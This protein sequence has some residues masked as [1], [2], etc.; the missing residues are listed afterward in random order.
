MKKIFMYIYSLHIGGGAENIMHQLSLLL[1][2]NDYDVVVCSMVDEEPSF[3]ENLKANDIRI[4]RLKMNKRNYFFKLLELY[5]LLRK[6][7]PA[8]FLAWLWPAIVSG[9]LIAKMAGLK[10]RVANLRGPAMTKSYLKIILDRIFSR[11]YTHYIA[12]TESVKNIFVKR[13][14]FKQK[15]IT[16]INNGIDFKKKSAKYLKKQLKKEFALAQ[17]EFVVGTIGR[18]YPEKNQQLL[19]AAAKILKEQNFKC[20]IFLVGNGPAEKA[21][22]EQIIANNLLEY[23]I[24]PG[25]QSDVYKFLTMYDLFVLPSLYEGHPSS[26]LQAWYLKL[27]I[28]ATKVIGIKDIVID[29]YNG[30][31]FSKDEPAELARIIINMKN[32]PDFAQKIA[33][34]GYNTVKEKY[35]IE[36]MNK[37]YLNYFEQLCR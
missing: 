5:H 35:N 19:V 14:K 18:L 25:W 31:L 8:V 32:Y 17:N 2:K 34:N 15:K 7:R 20:K 22:K 13:E 3:E 36:T 30:L 24:L 26:I 23:F 37:N 11:G 12:V 10:I 33:E 21:I 4:Y 1:K 28:A 16:V 9:N 29:G 6:E 27:P